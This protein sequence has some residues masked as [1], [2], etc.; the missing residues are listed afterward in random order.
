M[1]LK[2]SEV[3]LDNGDTDLIFDQLT[4]R[5]DFKLILDKLLEIKEVRL[6]KET[7][8]ESKKACLL[9]TDNFQFVLVYDS[10]IFVWNYMYAVNR[11]NHG[12]LKELCRSVAEFIS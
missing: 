2:I 4:K 12:L 10:D 9:E 7:E 3:I 6:V 5:K 11:E 1:K 8:D